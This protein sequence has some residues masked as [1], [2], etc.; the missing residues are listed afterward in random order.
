[1]LQ[2]DAYCSRIRKVLCRSSGK[3]SGFNVQRLCQYSTSENGFTELI[4]SI[5]AGR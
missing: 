1:M 5:T 4:Q 2:K 3:M